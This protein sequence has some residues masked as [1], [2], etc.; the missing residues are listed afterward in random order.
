MSINQKKKRVVKQSL[1]MG[2]LTSSF[3]VF[4]SKALGLLYYSPLSSLAGE[5]NMAFYSITY[6]YYDILLKISQAGIPFAIAALVAKYVAKEDYKTAMVV[7]KLGTSIVMGISFIS[8]LFFIIFS[9]SLARQSMGSLAT[10]QDVQRLKNLFLI[11][12]IAVILVP[13]LSSIRSYYQ[14]LKRLDLYASSQVLEQFV[15]VVC[16]IGLGYLF[17]KVMGF[18]SIYAIYM[19]IAAAG[20]AAA[21]SIFFFKLSTKDDD[22]RMKKLVKA[23]SSD[24][25]TKKEVFKE[26]LYLGVPYLGISILGTS[27][28]LVNTTFFLNYVTNVG[29]M[30]QASA[31][32]SLGILQANCS[33]LNAIPQV[34]TSGFCAGLVPYLTESYEKK[35][36]KKLSKQVLQII[37]TVLYIL[38]PVLVLFFVLAKDI[39]YA[40]YGSN[41]LELATNLFRASNSYGFTETILPIMSSVMITLRLR[42]ESVLTL[43][44]GFV[45]KTITFFIFVKFFWAYGMVISTCFASIVSMSIYFVILNKKFNI[46]FMPSL[47]KAIV[48]GLSSLIMIIPGIIVHVI[49]PIDYTSRIVTVLCL[50]I[51]S[52]VMM[53]AYFEVGR[54]FNLPQTVFGVKDIS[55]LK[56]LRRF[57]GRNATE[58]TETE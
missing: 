54:L 33:K 56:L 5:G 19:A 55:I 38:I 1:L 7:K 37:D 18:D 14:G 45:I 25:L 39:Y 28:P 44:N 10:A 32:L 35:D 57:K 12:I 52:F 22:K 53:F 3:G 46:N 58:S 11:L 20:I 40:M 13:Y 15:R 8:V 34:L 26:I 31:Q 24:A 36:Y 29:G 27:G 9:G 23:Q 51:V 17:V 16:I 42:K 49:L 6:T 41:N 4:I 2:A 48:I 21:V 47:K 30:D 50:G 43:L